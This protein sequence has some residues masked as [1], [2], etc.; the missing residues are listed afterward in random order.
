M[1]LL[2][3]RDNVPPR[4]YVLHRLHDPSKQDWAAA[5][6]YG[7][8]IPRLSLHLAAQAGAFLPDVQDKVRFADRCRRHGLPCIAT[9][10]AYRGGERLLPEGAFV[11]HQPSLWVKD[12]AGH[13]GA[14]ESCW[15]REGDRYRE[16]RSS[17]SLAPE[18]LE[19]RWRQRDCL[20]QPVL[21]AHPALSALSMGSAV[22]DFRV[23]SGIDRAGDVTIIAAQARLGAGGA[24][25]RWYITAAVEE[26]GGLRCPLLAGY[27]PLTRHPD[28]GA[29]LAIKVPYWPEALALVRNAH[30]AVPEFARFPLLGWDVA[31]TQEGPVLIE[32]NVGWDAVIPQAGSRPLGYTPLLRTALDWLA[33]E[34]ACG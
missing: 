26:D 8:E 24:R 28:S 29:D 12:L 4:E 15:R 1:L 7:D 31:V 2:A 21:V 33:K 13:R 14:G 18:A 23:I 25:P 19:A 20:V 10:A 27:Q 34:Q 11:P 3:L 17:V 16:E 9:L 6:F 32:T 22:A 30:G 5:A